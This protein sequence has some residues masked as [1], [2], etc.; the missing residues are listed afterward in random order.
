[1]NKFKAPL[2]RFLVGSFAGLFCGLVAWGYSAFAHV[3]I[4][5]IQIIFGLLF[6]A[7][8]C[9]VIAV[10]TSIESLMDNFPLI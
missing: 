5:P 8:S 4:S 10:S 3:A 7:L 1:M 9:G 6:V 2:K